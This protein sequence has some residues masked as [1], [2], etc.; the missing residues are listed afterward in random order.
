MIREVELLQVKERG[1]TTGRLQSPLK[2]IRPSSLSPGEPGARPALLQAMV[3]LRF[4]TLALVTGTVGLRRKC[5]ASLSYFYVP[6]PT[7]QVEITVSWS[8][9]YQA[10]SN[11]S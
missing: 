7:T 10:W 11:G 2:L 3:I 8:E 4:I 1:E 5:R 6:S 9:L